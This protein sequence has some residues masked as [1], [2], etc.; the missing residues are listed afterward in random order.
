MR[1]GEVMK[2]DTETR[3]A[4]L[5]L[6]ELVQLLLLHRELARWTLAGALERRAP[7]Q[8]QAWIA[9]QLERLQA[10]MPAGPGWS[11]LARSVN[12]RQLGP[13]ESDRRHAVLVAEWLGLAEGL[14]QRSGIAG[15]PVGRSLAAALADLRSNLNAPNLAIEAQL[16]ACYR[17]LGRLDESAGQP[18]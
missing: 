2:P 17:A 1:K 8:L 18:A 12:E 15:H 16:A 5:R 9:Q 14:S 10:C 11:G 4:L 3:L 6:L 7:R 13:G